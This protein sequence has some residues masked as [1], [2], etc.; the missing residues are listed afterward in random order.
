VVAALLRDSKDRW[1]DWD[2]EDGGLR[3]RGDDVLGGAGLTKEEPEA[4]KI[5]STK[6]EEEPSLSEF[7]IL[8][9]TLDALLPYCTG[10]IWGIIPSLV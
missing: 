5:F 8:D 7:W 4:G 9:F 1:N 3:R 10:K 2:V 6:G